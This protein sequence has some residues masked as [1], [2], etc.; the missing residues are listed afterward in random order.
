MAPASSPL[1]GGTQLTLS[2]R[3]L[4][5]G[6]Y[7]CRF[8]R[9]NPDG[10][11]AS[12][13]PVRVTAAALHADGLVRCN[14]SDG[15]IS[16]GADPFELLELS[17]NGQQYH[18]ASGLNPASAAASSAS[19][20]AG[21]AGQTT[22][23]LTLGGALA[24]PAPH[25]CRFGAGVDASGPVVV[26]GTAVPG[27]PRGAQATPSCAPRPPSCGRPTPCMVRG[28]SMATRCLACPSSTR[29]MGSSTR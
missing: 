16:G 11:G 23:A 27:R 14:S 20:V 7:R 28:R 26:P 5:G 4:Q 22:V 17:L 24:S 1:A 25:T 9:R 18:A 2:G 19:P 10:I 8:S 21:P 15:A 13:R 3:R 6:S 12:T 29:S